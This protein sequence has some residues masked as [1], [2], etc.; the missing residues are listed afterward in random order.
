MSGNAD[1]R[2]FE[3]GTLDYGRAADS[4]AACTGVIDVPAVR[5]WWTYDPANP[6]IRQH[7]PTMDDVTASRAVAKMRL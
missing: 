3:G 5:W 7:L 2:M 1:E 6:G 4:F